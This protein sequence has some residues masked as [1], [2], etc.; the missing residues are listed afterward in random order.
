[1]EKKCH[2]CSSKTDLKIWKG[3][4]H[5]WIVCKNCRELHEAVGLWTYVADIVSSMKLDGTKFSS[6]AKFLTFSRE[7]LETF[8]P[9][10]QKYTLQGVESKNIYLSRK[11]PYSRDGDVFN[12]RGRCFDRAIV[13]GQTLNLHMKKTDLFRKTFFD[14]NY[15]LTTVQPYFYVP[16]RGVS[17]AADYIYVLNLD[18]GAFAMLFKEQGAK[19]PEAM[20]KKLIL[21]EKR[22]PIEKVVKMKASR[23]RRCLLRYYYL[24][25]DI[26]ETQYMK[27]KNKTVKMME[28]D[29]SLLTL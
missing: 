3:E 22:F 18:L 21:I 11:Y 1:M 25:G 27:H 8:L 9:Q 29:E 28:R 10:L 17:I 19:L 20:K 16:I 5:K 23:Y 13:I 2:L 24:K 14:V 12:F 26:T 4:K 7:E 15:V 6:R